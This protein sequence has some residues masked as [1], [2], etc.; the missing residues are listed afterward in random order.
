MKKTVLGALLLGSV[1]LIALS[2]HADEP[3]GWYVGANGGLNWNDTLKTDLGHGRSGAGPGTFNKV[4]EHE[5]FGGGA[6]VGYNWGNNIRT[7]I[8]GA[9]SENEA[10]DEFGRAASGRTDAWR[11]YVN[12][13]YD[14]DLTQFNIS[15]PIVPYIGAGLGAVNWGQQAT[16][17][18]SLPGTPRISGNGTAMS[19]QGIAGVA[20]NIDDNWAATLD[21][22]HIETPTLEF[23]ANRPKYI[24]NDLTSN[25][26][27]V[28]VRYTFSE[29]APAPAPAKTAGAAA[30]Q[31]AQA[32]AANSYLVFFDFNKYNLTMDAKKIVDNAAGAAKGNS[33]V[34]KI[35]VTG[36]TDT[37][38]SDAYNMKLSRRRADSVKAELVKQ[39][40]PANEIVEYAKGKRDPLVPTGDGVR[41]PQNRR[42]EIVF[43]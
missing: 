14:F 9:Y 35:D 5:G 36:H 37:V 31:K 42:V 11:G 25:Q 27:M 29:P 23:G 4:K 34:T 40:I 20:Y 28:G 24:T 18:Q 13:F 3:A 43:K 7:E 2:A 17:P 10:K 1:S 30:P 19:Y 32:P 26:V 21:Y 12:A 22:R 38:G 8:E 39:G 15:L 6:E 33:A 16:Y 41:E